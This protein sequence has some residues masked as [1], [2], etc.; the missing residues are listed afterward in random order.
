MGERVV[1]LHGRGRDVTV[2]SY[3]VTNGINMIGMFGLL[4]Q[5]RAVV[6][7]VILVGP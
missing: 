5:G 2:G 3:P 4:A 1:E 7:G 6:I